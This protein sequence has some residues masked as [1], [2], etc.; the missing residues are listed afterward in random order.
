[1]V[2]VSE[3]VTNAVVHGG[4]NVSLLLAGSVADGGEGGEVVCGVGD[5]STV[6]PRMRRAR[7][8]DE[9]GRGL[10]LVAA[11]AS[12]CGWYRA[13]AGKVVWFSQR[14]P[15]ADG[16]RGDGFPAEAGPPHPLLDGAARW[17]WAA[18]HP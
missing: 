5:A 10:A 16:C 1:T 14:L 2:M 4:G 17:R 11:L 6:S 3:L 18:R 15:S 12:R 9:G 13:G 8:G 7:P